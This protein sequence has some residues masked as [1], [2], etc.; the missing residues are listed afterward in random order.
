M[1]LGIARAWTVKQQLDFM[2]VPINI[3]AYEHPKSEKGGQ[4]RR[5]SIELNMTNLLLD[6]YEKLLNDL[7]VASGIGDRPQVC[8]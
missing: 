8:D 6:Y 3:G 4:Y 1:E 7:W 2:N 5:I